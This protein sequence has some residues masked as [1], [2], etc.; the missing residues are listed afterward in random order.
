[1][2]LLYEF[3]FSFFVQ[4]FFANYFY[5]KALETQSVAAVN[6]L[7]SLSGVF[8]LILAAFPIPRLAKKDKFSLTKLLIIVVR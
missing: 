5:A 7:S 4:W 1:M 3:A 8:V 6:T 2:L